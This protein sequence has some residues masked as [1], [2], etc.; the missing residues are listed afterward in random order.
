MVFVF[1]V[2]MPVVHHFLRYGLHFPKPGLWV[3]MRF[4]DWI[5]VELSDALRSRWLEPVSSGNTPLH[6]ISIWYESFTLQ[7]FYSTHNVTMKVIHVGTLIATKGLNNSTQEVA[8]EAACASCGG[9]QPTMNAICYKRRKKGHIQ[10]VW[11]SLHYK[12]KT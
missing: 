6:Y 11:K 4:N 9:Q 5:A 12:T 10:E 8:E 3:I 7:W 1:S 2:R